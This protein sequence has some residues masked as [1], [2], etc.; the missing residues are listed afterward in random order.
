MYWHLSVAPYTG[1][2]PHWGK[3]LQSLSTLYLKVMHKNTAYSFIQSSVH[4]R[5]PELHMITAATIVY[6]IWELV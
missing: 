5:L 2:A 4:F 3:I 6:S 1:L